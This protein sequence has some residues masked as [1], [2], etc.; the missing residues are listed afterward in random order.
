MISKLC[1]FYRTGPDREP[2]SEDPEVIRRE[3]EARR[4]RVFW[5]ITIGYGVFYTCRL[6][7]AVVK[8]PL[9][10]EGVFDP[11][12]LGLIGSA[13]LFVYALGRFTNGFLAD[14]LNLRRF[15]STGL[16]VSATINLLLGFTE[17]F[18]IF[19]FLWGLNGWFQSMGSAPSVVSLTQWF[20]HRERGT[21]YGVWSVSHC[22]GEA[23]TFAGTALVV[24][25]LGWRAG[26][27]APG[28]LGVLGAWVML[29]THADRPQTY[30]LP[31]VADYKKD[32][33]GTPA[34]EPRSI[35]WHQLEVLRNPWVWV[36]AL[37]AASMYATRYAV[38]NWAMLFLQLHKGHELADAGLVV[39]ASPLVGLLGTATSGF[40]SD[41]VFDSRRNWPTL[42]YGL[43]QI[44]S[45]VAFY[46][47]PRGELAADAVALAIFG[48]ATGGL[49]VFLG[50]LSAIDIV[51]K[52][53][54]GAAMGVIGL[55]SYLGA[56]LQEVL[57]GQLIKSTEQL[58]DGR[59]TYSFQSAFAFWISTAVLSLAL[60]A[61]TWNVKPQ[62]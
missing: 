6:S 14:R 39:S 15:M 11:G 26:F 36:L 33:P 22:L 5:T 16:W 47:I 46:L 58:V 44:A 59:M 38:N 61:T 30:G 48:F 7:L 50:G 24:S 29:R 37:S 49:L 45:L 32:H 43:L 56:G 51:S 41:R 20:S 23:V 18:W 40:I 1:G 34:A 27:W 35:G 19:F 31:P 57:S 62:E 52:K 55:F 4:R 10:D 21:R 53:A 3:Y 8:E 12:E 28:A 17:V 9:V 13:L 42:L 25:A 60:A 54:T 2:L